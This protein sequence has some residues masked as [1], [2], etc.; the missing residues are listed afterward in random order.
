MNT[1]EVVRFNTFEGLKKIT[2]KSCQVES[3]IK[4]GATIQLATKF[5]TWRVGG[6]RERAVIK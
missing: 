4:A 5:V 3:R 2:E 6:Y 1:V